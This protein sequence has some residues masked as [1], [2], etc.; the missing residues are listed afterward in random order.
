MDY[1]RLSKKSFHERIRFFESHSQEIST[2]STSEKSEIQFDY[3]CCLFEIGRYRKFL[4]QVDPLIEEV[5]IENIYE[6]EGKDVYKDL[7]SKKAASSYNISDHAQADYILK[8]L[9]S[10]YPEDPFFG[11]FSGRM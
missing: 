6:I 9:M 1:Y 3:L 10:L 7:L 11:R 8:S 2:L 5:I 4:A